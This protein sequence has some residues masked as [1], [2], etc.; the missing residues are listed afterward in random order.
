M[1]KT[2]LHPALS[3]ERCGMTMRDLTLRMTLLT[4]TLGTV[5]KDGELP[6]SEQKGALLV[7]TIKL[8]RYL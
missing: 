5:A 2:M 3:A 8:C 1:N 4:T 6:R 7:S